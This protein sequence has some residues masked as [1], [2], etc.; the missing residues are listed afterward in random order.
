MSTAHSRCIAWP[1]C[2]IDS[3]SAEVSVPLPKLGPGEARRTADKNVGV[4]DALLVADAFGIAV[5]SGPAAACEDGVGF[6]AAEA[7]H[8]ERG[9]RRRW[10]A[11]Q[12]LGVGGADGRGKAIGWAEDFDGSV[13]AVVAGCDAEMCALV[14]GKRIA[15]AGDGSDQLVPADL[16][17]EIAVALQRE[18]P[19]RPTGLEGQNEPRR[20]RT[21][22]PRGRR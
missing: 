2:C 19:E 5:V 13:L 17:T 16:F 6:L 4:V 11:A 7:E 14:G 20:R 9:G 3:I 21:R 18:V 8:D 22:R 10:I 1:C 12:P 15:D